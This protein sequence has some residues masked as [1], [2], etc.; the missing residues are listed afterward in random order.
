MGKGAGQAGTA[1]VAEAD[2]AVAAGGHGVVDHH[3]VHRAPGTRLVAVA[4]L[5]AAD[6]DD[7]DALVPQGCQ[8]FRRA[9]R[10]VP[11]GMGGA[12]VRLPSSGWR[13]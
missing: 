6:L 12:M 9:V 1:V 8:S 13:A 10:E 4:L 3:A 7:G 11:A 5:P 2:G